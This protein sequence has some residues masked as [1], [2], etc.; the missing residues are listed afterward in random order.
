MGIIADHPRFNRHF[1]LL[2]LTSC[3]L[4][5]SAFTWFI[6]SVPTPLSPTPL[7]S[8]NI[9]SLGLAVAMCGFTLG[10]QNPLT[11]EL[12][13]EVS[14]PV[15]EQYSAGFITLFNNGLGIVFIFA[16]PYFSDGLMNM[17]MWATVVIGGVLVMW[18]RESYLRR[19]DDEK[20]KGGHDVM[21]EVDVEESEVGN[22]IAKGRGGAVYKQRAVNGVLEEL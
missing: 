12:G 11:Y 20:R 8:S 10:L 19:D 15:P 17:T 5:F 14:Y 2:L 7:L 16:Q 18:V 1:K 13:A 3:A 9:V 4:T 21:D 6:F 22:G